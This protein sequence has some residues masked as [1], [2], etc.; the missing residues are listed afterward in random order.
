VAP[1][2]LRTRVFLWDNIL[3]K[4]RL[5]CY[6][7]GFNLYHSIDD[8]GPKFN[9]LKWLDLWSLAHAFVKTSTEQLKSVYYFSALAYWLK[10]PKQRHEEFIKAIKHFG[11]TPIL[12]H[13]K[14]KPG[15]CKSCGFTTQKTLSI[16]NR[17]RLQ[18]KRYCVPTSPQFTDKRKTRRPNYYEV[19]S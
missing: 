17:W 10:Q 14:E 19:Q 7:D 16:T 11:V 12:G 4:K 5:N 2:C 9:Y 18:G 1:G 8:L 15:Y 3:S 6:I 13:F